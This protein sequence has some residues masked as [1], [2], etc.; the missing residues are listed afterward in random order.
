MLVMK[1]KYQYGIGLLEALVALLIISIGMMS[2]LK[3]LTTSLQEISNVQ[4]RAQAALMASGLIA[5][6]WTKN[7]SIKNLKEQ[8]AEESA[9][10]YKKFLGQTK[11]KLPGV[12]DTINQPAIDIKD[13]GKIIINMQW[14]AAGEATVHKIVFVTKINE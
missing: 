8:Y 3:L 6:M 10:G 13:D 5:E 12:S 2:V 1:K 7:H 4:Y 11:K 14:Q 9:E